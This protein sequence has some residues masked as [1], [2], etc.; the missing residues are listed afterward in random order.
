MHLVQ[1]VRNDIYIYYDYILY[2]RSRLTKTSLE[3][4]YRIP[5]IDA[6][7]LNIERATN[8]HTIYAKR[9]DKMMFQHYKTLGG[10][11]YYKSRQV[12]L[13]RRFLICGIS[14]PTHTRHC[15]FLQLSLVSVHDSCN[16]NLMYFSISCWETFNLV[17]LLKIFLKCRLMARIM[18][19]K[20]NE[21]YD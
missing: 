8:Y 5:T 11:I 2:T 1:S 20:L 16:N 13:W 21:H 18:I 12:N 3:K 6:I 14:Y 15:S 10:C 19:M 4:R 17:S 9:H 7:K